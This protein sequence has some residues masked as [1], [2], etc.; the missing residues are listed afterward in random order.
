MAAFGPKIRARRHQIQGFYP[1]HEDFT[2]NLGGLV[3]NF[4]SQPGFG[5]QIAALTQN[6]GIS[7]QKSLDPSSDLGPFGSKPL[8]F[9][10]LGSKT[11]FLP[12]KF[13]IFGSNLGFS[14]KMG[15][16]SPKIPLFQPIFWGFQLQIAALTQKWGISTQRFGIIWVKTPQIWDFGVKKPHFCT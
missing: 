11:P 10:I 9:G 8:R 2:P 1:K 13:G 12:L 6:R 16:L 4:G 15:R 7:T 14:P 3:P 5:L